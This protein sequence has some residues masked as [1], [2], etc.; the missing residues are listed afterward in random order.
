MSLASLLIPMAVVVD[1]HSSDMQYPSHTTLID[2]ILHEA[3]GESLMGQLAVLEVVYER[4]YRSDFPSE[5]SKVVYQPYQFSWTIEGH[6][7]GEPTEEEELKA[8]QLVYSFLYDGLPDSP[9]KGA[10]HYLNPSVIPDHLL[11]NWYFEYDFVG[12]VGNH[13]FFKRPTN[14]RRDMASV[15]INW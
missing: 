3:R 14:V 10:T 15:S 1:L 8:A 13:E 12:K 6:P 11:P 7:I 9:V 5:V 2:N 4:A